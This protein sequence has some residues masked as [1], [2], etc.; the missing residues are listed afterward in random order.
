MSISYIFDKKCET[1]LNVVSTNFL[2]PCYWQV[3]CHQYLVVNSIIIGY[4][5]D[6][7]AKCVKSNLLHIIALVA[8]F[9]YKNCKSKFF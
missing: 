6:I 8:N 4:E 3:I 9:R 5:F 7:R 1:V 2:Y